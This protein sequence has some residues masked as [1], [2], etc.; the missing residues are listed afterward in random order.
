MSMMVGRGADVP[1]TVNLQKTSAGDKSRETRPGSQAKASQVKSSPGISHERSRNLPRAPPPL[2]QVLTGSYDPLDIKG[3][4]ENV[5]RVVASYWA[6]GIPCTARARRAVVASMDPM[7]RAARH[8][9]PMAGTTAL[10]DLLAEVAGRRREA[11]DTAARIRD[12]ARA[13]RAAVL[14][15]RVTGGARTTHVRRVTLLLAGETAP[16]RARVRAAAA[17]AAANS[18]PTGT[19]SIGLR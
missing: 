14:A 13:R 9:M 2:P 12:L 3:T 8:A 6:S 16:R 11:H 17:A 7:Q 19:T 18:G 15:A 4:T 1:E 10:Q 5:Y